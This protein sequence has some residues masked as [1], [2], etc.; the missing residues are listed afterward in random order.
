LGGKDT[1]YWSEKIPIAINADSS[2]YLIF[3]NNKIDTLG[4]SYK[5]HIE[6]ESKNCGFTILLDSFKLL[7]LSTFDSVVFEINDKT[8][9]IFE[10]SAK[11]VYKVN[12]FH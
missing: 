2:V 4:I 9:T 1:I 7:K 3:R 6:Y 12:I 8:E 5:R 10:T 11:N